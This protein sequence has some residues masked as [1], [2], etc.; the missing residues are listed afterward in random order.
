MLS[1]LKECLS[2]FCCFV[3]WA[4]IGEESFVGET[5]LSPSD[6]NAIHDFGS[7]FSSPDYLLPAENYL[8]S[9]KLVEGSSLGKRS[10]SRALFDDMKKRM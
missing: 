4:E 9:T 1:F 8:E 5:L 10:V 3:F 6:A 7:E 2:T